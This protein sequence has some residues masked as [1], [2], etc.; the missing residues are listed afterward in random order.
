ML[1]A[2]SER[3]APE[4]AFSS[5][6]VVRSALLAL[7]VSIIALS[8]QAL[9]PLMTAPAPMALKK[10]VP[11][12]SQA[13]DG[14]CDGGF[15]AYEPKWRGADFKHAVDMV[16]AHEVEEWGVPPNI[17]A[18]AIFAGATQEGA[19]AASTRPVYFVLDYQ[20][21]LG[22]AHWQSE[23]AVFLREWPDI[24]LAYP[25]AHIVTGSERTYKRAVFFLYGVASERVV[26]L[27]DVPRKNYCIF[28]PFHM[29]TDHH[30]DPQHFYTLW[31]AH[32]KYM[33]CA[34]GI[35]VRG[36]VYNRI[37]RSTP[38]D[39]ELGPITPVSVLVMPR[40]T[41]ENLRRSDRTYPGF[42]QLMH[43][44]E[45]NNGRVLHTDNITD[46]RVQVRTIASARIVVLPEGSA[47][48]A[49]GSLAA[50]AVVIVIGTYLT[51]QQSLNPR[52]VALYD[53]VANGCMH[54]CNHVLSVETAADVL[55]AIMDRFAREVLG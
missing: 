21:E 18:A 9:P 43:W 2:S 26:L 1:V 39:A 41:K 28:A 7:I 46:F 13:S 47:Y 44:A 29:I 35:N 17:T 12:R 24:L 6:T 40:G 30:L 55:P 5:V 4:A 37:S 25:D 22:Y 33:Q 23:C 8:L 36:T 10:A 54:G 14:P 27:A 20:K 32:I 51:A 31:D 53:F 45:A 52:V 11:R 48:S 42:E 34:S 15:A 19:T 49:S 3:R 50:H 16:S 38:L